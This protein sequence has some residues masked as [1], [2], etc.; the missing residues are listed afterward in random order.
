MK[1]WDFTDFFTF[2]YNKKN[3]YFKVIINIDNRANIYKILKER[4]FGFLK[5]RNRLLY[6]RKVDGIYNFI[7]LQDFEYFFLRDF[8][9]KE[10][11][12]KSKI[13]K[14]KDFEKLFNEIVS[15][16]IK[17]VK[18][19]NLFK[20]FLYKI[21]NEKDLHI[22]NLKF[23]FQYKIDYENKKFID[24]FEKN[25]FRK[26]LDLKSNISKGNLVYYKNLKSKEYIVFNK[27]GSQY[28]SW[29]AK[30]NKEMDIGNAMPVYIK[31]LKLNFDLKNDYNF[32]KNYLK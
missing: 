16:E 17:L 6:F 22:I 3:D 10:L 2:D 8:L 31:C 4:G 5:Y 1:N 25:E 15:K 7:T 12:L 28:D 9:E 19:D 11:L 24:F 30:F 20:Y 14:A 18:N 32:L 26:V 23:D 13:F 21:P 29:I 27:I